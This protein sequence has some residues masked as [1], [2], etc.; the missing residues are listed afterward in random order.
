MHD[1][2]IRNLQQQKFLALPKVLT[3]LSTL[4]IY[5]SRNSQHF[6]RIRRYSMT[7]D[8]YNSRNSQH[9]QRYVSQRIAIVDLQQQKFLALPKGSVLFIFHVGIYNSRNSQHFQRREDKFRKAMIYNSRNSQHFQRP[10]FLNRLLCNLQ[11]QKFLALPKAISQITS[12]QNLQQQ[13][14]LA[15]PKADLISVVIGDLQQQKFL[16][17]PKATIPW[18]PT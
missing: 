10:C 1:V 8:I 7:A 9:F 18:L 4:I 15:L 17:L 5:N 2:T 3:R 6:Q 14:F 16:A 11:Q 13:K 12:R